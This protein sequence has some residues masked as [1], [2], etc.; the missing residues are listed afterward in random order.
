[1]KPRSF[2]KGAR[3]DT[4]H[5]RNE[6][7]T[8]PLDTGSRKKTDSSLSVGHGAWQRLCDRRQCQ[9]GHDEMAPSS[10]PKCHGVNWR[11]GAG[12]SWQPPSMIDTE[13]SRPSGLHQPGF[14][15]RS[16]SAAMSSRSNE[17]VAQVVILDPQTTRIRHV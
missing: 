8:R 16:V 5:T 4:P 2:L 15:Y 6:I 13:C 17:L 9:S 3:Q 7:D 11:H 1:M 12:T 10:R 14:Y